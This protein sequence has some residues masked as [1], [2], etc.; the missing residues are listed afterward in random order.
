MWHYCAIPDEPSRE[1]VCLDVLVNGLQAGFDVQIS[2]LQN[3]QRKAKRCARTVSNNRDLASSIVLQENGQSLESLAIASKADN[4]ATIELS[5]RAQ[6]DTEAV[7][8]LTL[9]ALVYLP[10]SV[11]LVRLSIP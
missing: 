6:E 7:K 5:K 2:Q 11:V 8:A 9:V 3:L 10:I 1:A 4:E